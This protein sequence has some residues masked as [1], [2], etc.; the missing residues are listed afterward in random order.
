MT[1]INSYGTLHVQGDITS[2]GLMSV[3]MPFA[4]C[5]TSQLLE[6][7]PETATWIKLN[8]FTQADFI[9]DFEHTSNGTLTYTGPKTL[10][11][12][13]SATLYGTNSDS[14]H[15]YQF[16]KNS[17]RIGMMIIFSAETNNYSGTLQKIVKLEHGDTIDIHCQNLNS[18]S[19][20][21]TYINLTIEPLFNCTC[22][23]E[24]LIQDSQANV[25]DTQDDNVDDNQDD[26]VD[27][28]QDDN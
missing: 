9:K 8:T 19:K 21:F 1:F 23:T 20:I 10:Y 2:A 15:L 13:C 27:D 25:N 11:F 14:T 17:E 5:Y 28:N 3:Q 6:T 12:K 7:Q 26:N 4:E 22:L 18:N 16:A 24:S